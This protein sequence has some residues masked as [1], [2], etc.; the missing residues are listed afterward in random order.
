MALPQQ[1]IDMAETL[2][3]RHSTDAATG[4]AAAPRAEAAA[5]LRAMGAPARRDEYWK[6]TDPTALTADAAPAGALASDAF[7][8][9]D[10]LRAVFV[11]GVF[12]ADLS[13]TLA[14]EGAEICTL[15][16]AM[17]ADIHW[18]AGL[19]GVL[20]GAEHHRTPRPLAALNTAAATQGL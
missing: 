20:E 8:G 13:D 11:D 6:Y 12:R 10:A 16:N 7:A 18:A 19:F 15:A 14:L 17:A 5:R 2:L 9:V 4:W 1:K 3:A